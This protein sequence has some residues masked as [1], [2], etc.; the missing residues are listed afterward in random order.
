M[1]YF[2]KA[3]FRVANFTC[4]GFNDGEQQGEQKQAKGNQISKY[5][6]IYARCFVVVFTF[7]FCYDNYARMFGEHP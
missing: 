6:K 4:T 3:C 7:D 5:Y 2:D 1:T